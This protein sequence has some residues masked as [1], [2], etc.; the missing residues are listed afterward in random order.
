MAL[1]GKH[2]EPQ[3]LARDT[4]HGSLVRDLLIG[5]KTG[6]AIDNQGEQLL[7]ELVDEDVIEVL[8][9]APS[10]S[11]PAWSGLQYSRQGYRDTPWGAGTIEHYHYRIKAR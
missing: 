4:F 5:L 9:R 2:I 8:E 3:L 11:Q 7:R 1:Y 6:G 10:P